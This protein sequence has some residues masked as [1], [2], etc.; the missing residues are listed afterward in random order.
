MRSWSV[1][2]GADVGREKGRRSQRVK[3]GDEGWQGEVFKV[4]GGLRAGAAEDHGLA[5][6]KSSRDDFLYVLSPC[7]AFYLG[8]EQFSSL[9][10]FD[11]VAATIDNLPSLPILEICCDKAQAIGD[12]ATS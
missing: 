2:A 8:C 5:S 4:R 6:D 9:I 11:S 1:V 3:G 12:Y 7:H 10:P